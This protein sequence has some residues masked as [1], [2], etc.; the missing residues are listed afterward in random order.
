M[1][2]AK[3]IKRVEY[4]PC[5]GLFDCFK[6]FLKEKQGKN[7]ASITLDNYVN[8]FN[9]FCDY[10]QYDDNTSIEAIDKS[11]VI[12]WQSAMLESGKKTAGI[13]HHLRDIRTFFYWCMDD[14]QGYL[15]RFKINLVQS[16]EETVKT[17]TDDDI[18]ALTQKPHPRATFREW[19]DWM[20]VHWVLATGNR[21]SSIC[22]IRISDID[23]NGGFVHIAHTK[24]NKILP[25]L[26][27]SVDLLAQVKSYIKSFGLDNKKQNPQQWLFPSVSGNQLN[28][29]A[30]SQ[31]FSKYCNDRKTTKTSIHGLR[32]TFT[33]IFITNGGKMEQVKA[34]LGHSSIVM[35]DRYMHMFGEDLKESLKYIPY[36]KINQNKTRRN[37]FRREDIFD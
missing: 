35:S 37:K 13:N 14:E 20:I 17:F 9:Y 24:N 18:I 2:V 29:H 27:L 32:H 7:L 10:H 33:K 36:D 15:P 6:E 1:G 12:A 30:L 25:P 4:Q 19:R 16:Q 22:N 31:S 28:P 8:S 21:A 11:K 3:S 34:M 5:Y 26:P 23:F